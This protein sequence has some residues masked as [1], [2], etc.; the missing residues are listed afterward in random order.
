MAVLLVAQY[1]LFRDIKSK[2]E[3]SSSLENSLLKHNEVRNYIN[4][5]KKILS[6]L[7]EDR[8]RV[9][10][11]IVVRDGDVAFLEDLEGL[12]KN[13]N[14]SVEVESL[15]LE[16]SEDLS[17]QGLTTLKIRVRVIGSWSSIYKF[18]SQ[19]E[20]MPFKVIID[21]VNLISKMSGG[22][23]VIGTGNT[24]EGSFEIRVLKYI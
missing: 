2:T 15:S 9:D 12:A 21:K 6:S 18:L 7:G 19:T 16:S 17:V 10:D 11:Y 20:N 1:F 8:K 3:E 13:G 5:T 24:W 23:S 4:S 22:N 14:L